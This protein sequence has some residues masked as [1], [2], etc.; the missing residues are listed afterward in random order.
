MVVTGR[1]LAERLERQRTY[2]NIETVLGPRILRH[3]QRQ[4][5]QF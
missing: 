1:D 3:I 5:K 4:M 2:V